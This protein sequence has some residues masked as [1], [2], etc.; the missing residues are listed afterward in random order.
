M[1]IFKY[2]LLVGWALL[3][4]TVAL[5]F[6]FPKSMSHILKSIADSFVLVPASLLAGT[7]L[8]GVMRLYKAGMKHSGH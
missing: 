6:V 8:Y 4:G 2:V 3:F 1:K 7:G 5:V